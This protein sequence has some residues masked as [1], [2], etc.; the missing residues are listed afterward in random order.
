MAYRL[1]YRLAGVEWWRKPGRPAAVFTLTVL[2]AIWVTFASYA[3]N[4]WYSI[5]DEANQELYGA[6]NVMGAHTNAVFRAARTMQSV[7]DHWLAEDFSIAQQHPLDE[8]RNLLAK[9]QGN[10]RQLVTLGLVDAEDHGF[11]RLTLGKVFADRIYLGDRDYIE[12][13][14]DKPAGQEFIGL[15]ILGRGGGLRTVPIAMRAQPND[16]GVKY[17]GAYIT[18]KTFNDAFSHLTDIA[19]AVVGITRS[20]GRILF[21]WPPNDA[22]RGNLIAGFSDV[23][24]KN[25]TDLMAASLPSPDGSG[26]MLA[27]FGPVP[28]EPLHVFAAIK[29]ADLHALF[30]AT[31]AFPTLLACLT[32]IVIALLGSWVMKLMVSQARRS[33]ELS[34]A[35]VKAEA[36]NESKSQFLAN[37]SHELRTPLNA[38]IGFSEVIS[39]EIYGP[40]GVT[41]YREYSKDITDAG[42]HLLGIITQILDM[43][44]LESGTLADTQTPADIGENIEACQRLL[45][46]KAAERRI[47]IVCGDMADL[48]PVRM[49]PV[50]LRQVIINLIGNAIKFS[51]AGGRIDVSAVVTPKGDLQITVADE[52]IGIK[53]E[54]MAELFQPFGQVEKAISRQYGGV[55]L[56]LVN[57]RRLVEA[58]GG[59]IWLESEYGV[60]TKA[61]VSL[62]IAA[63]NS[64]T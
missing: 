17:I 44:K 46:G 40:L 45:F 23:I 42:H 49:E 53:P 36:A 63:L 35:L 37:M 38:V 21:V 26:E 20:D 39:K 2:V 30:L 59:K 56:G 51:H 27:A 43:A 31:L 34:A 24:V 15:P 13:L 28:E 32:T 11:W 3:I 22:Q 14:R 8:L 5:E 6:K 9:L 25:Q 7:T 16:A 12:A 48:P 41:Q 29:R 47:D 18:E 58:Y 33:A 62:P 61:I 64:A 4:V 19:P 57:A 52:G 10:G 1:L 55:G 54:S 60:G 50:H